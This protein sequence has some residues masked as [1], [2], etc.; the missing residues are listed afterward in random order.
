M[1]EEN[2]LGFTLI[3]LMIV[4]AIVGILATIAIPAYQDYTVRAKVAEG[5]TLVAPIKAAVD[6]QFLEKGA[7]PSGGNASFD[8]PAA[9]SISGRYTQS[10]AVTAGKI[11]IQ[12]TGPGSG[13]GGATLVLAPTAAA[14]GIYWT[15]GAAG[16]TLPNRYRPANCRD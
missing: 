9:A 10:V 12:Y 1:P 13:M 16:S 4:V 15:C 2:S 6:E 11:T 3:E 8:L 14:G 7:I 5:L